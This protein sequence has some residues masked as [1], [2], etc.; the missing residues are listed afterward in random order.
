M[1][2][3]CVN[4]VLIIIIITSYVR[5]AAVYPRNLFHLYV[6]FIQ[7]NYLNACVYSQNIPFG[8]MIDSQRLLSLSL[9]LVKPSII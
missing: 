7:C 5:H 4:K 2:I 1:R 8:Q 3:P 9:V 6:S